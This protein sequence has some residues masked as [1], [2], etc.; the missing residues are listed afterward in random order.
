M[1]KSLIGALVMAAACVAHAADAKTDPHAAVKAARAAFEKES[2]PLFAGSR[3]KAC[4][5]EPS[6]V[7]F[8]APDATG[9]WTCVL[10]YA[11]DERVRFLDLEMKD[12]QFAKGTLKVFGQRPET[13]D[14][15]KFAELR[16]K[17][18]MIA[19][20]KEAV[21]YPPTSIKPVV[22]PGQFDDPTISPA[23]RHLGALAGSL[24]RLG[25][26]SKELGYRVTFRDAQGK[27]LDLGVQT[28]DLYA[29]KLYPILRDRVEE[30]YPDQKDRF[31][32]SRSIPYWRAGEVEYRGE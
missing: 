8:D 29:E 10:P 25:I 14:A 7:R 13:I 16:A 31:S 28:S 4:D 21:L 1:K 19:I 30:A 9:A 5:A 2:G 17:F 26:S 3:V 32:K 23:S 15:K 18:P 12:G 24:Q 6:A 22:K 11:E 27:T 20:K